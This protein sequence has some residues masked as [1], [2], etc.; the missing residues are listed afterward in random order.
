MTRAAGKA[1]SLSPDLPV[2]VMVSALNNQFAV[3]SAETWSGAIPT[4]TVRPGPCTQKCQPRTGCEG[5]RKQTNIGR[6]VAAPDRTVVRMT[7]TKVKNRM[8]QVLDRV[9]QGETVS[10]CG[11]K[12]SRQL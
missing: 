11:T 10:S 8:G 2:I 9:M 4:E 7:A 5:T 3:D 12:F 6:V 1:P